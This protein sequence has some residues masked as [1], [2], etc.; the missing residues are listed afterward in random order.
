MSY[1]KNVITGHRMRALFLFPT[2]ARSIFFSDKC[3]GSCVRDYTETLV[4]LYAYL[5]N[6]SACGKCSMVFVIL[7][8][9]EFR[10]I[11]SRPPQGASRLRTVGVTE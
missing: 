7:Y 6:L 10:E 4:F 9:I 1:G 11:P 5:S 8:P 2:C 3:S